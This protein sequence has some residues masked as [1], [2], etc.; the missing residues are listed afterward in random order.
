MIA[1]PKAR[2]L[3]YAVR[4]GPSESSSIDPKVIPVGTGHPSL[5]AWLQSVAPH[6]DLLS[7]G[8]EAQWALTAGCSIVSQ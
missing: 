8:D 6:L 7:C 5:T 3:V 4:I 1:N 2:T